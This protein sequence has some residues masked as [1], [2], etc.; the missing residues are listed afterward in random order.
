LR[1]FLKIVEMK[2]QILEG[3]SA[4]TVKFRLFDAR[5]VLSKW[6][7]LACVLVIFL[8]AYLLAPRFWEP[9]GESLKNWVSARIFRETG[10]FPIFHHAPLYNIYLQL[11]S[12]FDYPLSVQ[13]EHFVTHLFTYS[14]IF[15]LLRRFLPTAPALILICAWI[16]TL[17][18][19]E[20]GARVAGIGF[21]ALYFWINR[22]SVFNKGYFPALLGAAVLL[23]AAYIPFLLGHAVGTIIERRSNKE[24]IITASYSLRQGEIV[25]M[26]LKA[27]LLMLVILTISFQS[28]RLDNNVHAINY[29][30]APFPQKEILTVGCLAYGNWTYVMQNIPEFE[31]IYQDW[32]FTH[33]NV[34]GGASNV[35]QAMLSNPAIIFRNIISNIPLAVLTPLNFAVGFR[36]PHNF[37]GMVLLFFSWVLLPISFYR[38]FQ[39][40]KANN[41]IAH[42]YSMT[43]GTTA[44]IAALFLTYFNQRYVMVLLPVGLLMTAHIGTNLQFFMRFSWRLESNQFNITSNNTSSILRRINIASG[45]FLILLGTLTNK[46]VIGILFL[47]NGVTSSQSSGV[48]IWFLGLFLIGAGILLTIRPNT[49]S[50]ILSQIKGWHYSNTQTWFTNAIMILMAGCTLFYSTPGYGKNVTLDALFKNP[51]LLSGKMADAHHQLLAS[52]NRATK[53]LAL[54]EPWIR[55]FADVD[56]DRVFHALYLPPFED[57]SGETEKFLESLDVIWVSHNWSRQEPSLATQCYLRYKLHVK[58]FLEKALKTGW[59]VQEVEGF[60]KIYRRPSQGIVAVDMNNTREKVVREE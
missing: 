54:E 11:F 3:A 24:S 56:L 60:G 17:W 20:G 47:K 34:F 39:Y 9:G 35:L 6:E 49:F 32:Y 57:T 21:L 37:T 36:F 44:V 48:P 43:F 16:P 52:V 46:W 38:V 8:S 41:L 59:T 28:N 27:A 30:W 19:I 45:I 1:V 10:G 15:L 31:W 58:P 4:R 25:P 13:I 40:Y 7:F 18:T 14:S 5:S 12:F 51:F 23:D 22:K 2:N 53:I 50:T 42:V 33:K 55:S 29:P 26:I